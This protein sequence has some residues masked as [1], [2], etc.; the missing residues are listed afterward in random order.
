[1]DKIESRYY[2]AGSGIDTL[3]EGDKKRIRELLIG[4]KVVEVDGDH[5]RLDNG[6]VIR[7]EPNCGCGGCSSGWYEL[8]TLS[9]VDNMITRVEFE[10]D[11]KIGEYYYEEEK[12]YRIFVF[13][14]NEKINLLSIE[15]S[16]GNGYYGTGFELLVKTVEGVNND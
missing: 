8:K 10:Y 3:H 15:G 1:M 5:L 9:R 16:D 4:R 7:V 6:T 11:T 13:A 12:V 2:R 14:E